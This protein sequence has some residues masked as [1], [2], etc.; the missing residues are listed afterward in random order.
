MVGAHSVGV[1]DGGP[2]LPLTGWST[3]GGDLRISHFFGMH[4]LQLLPLLVLVL[5]ALA[6]RYARLTDDRLRLRLVLLGSGVYAAVF[7]LLLWQAMR[8]QPLTDP[9]GATLAVAGAILLAAVLG[10]YGF[11]R[12]AASPRG[13]SGPEAAEAPEAEEAAAV[14]GLT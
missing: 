8:G 10:T 1:P 11:L 6:P 5:F 9:D 14:K 13:G 4:A 3:T 7:L 12:A 2:S